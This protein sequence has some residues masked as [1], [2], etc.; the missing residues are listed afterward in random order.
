MKCNPWRWLWGLVPLLGLGGLMHMGGTFTAIEADL[1]RQAETALDAGGQGW[2]RVAFS[3]R[4][5]TMIGEAGDNSE[6]LRAVG[7]ARSVW[8]VRVVNDQSRLLEE[9]KN[10][11]WGAQLQNDG[12][13]R[14]TGFVPNAA[15]RQAIV[16][17]AKATFPSRD[18]D[19]RMKLAR[20]APAQA[21]WEG[22]ISFGLKQLAGLKSGGRV[23]LEG[24]NLMLEGEAADLGTYRGVK[25]A[26]QSSMPNGVRLR[27]DKVSPPVVKP[28]VWSAKS[29]GSQVQL[30]GYVPSER[31]RD[32]V[33]AAAKKAFPRAA[34]VDQTRV[35]AGE[36][37][38]W[39]AGVVASLGRLARLE[40]GSVD[41]RD[42]EMAIAGLATDDRIADEVRRGVKADLPRSFKSTEAIR[43]KEP[44]V[45]VVDPFTSAMTM[46]N[47]VLVLTGYVPS[48]AART[49]LV[50]TVKARLP[51][52]RIDDRL[53]IANGAPEGWLACAQ[54]GVGGLASLS[55]G[56]IELNRR[57]MT[58]TGTTDNESL[59]QSLPAAV[60]VGVG[61]ACNAQV[62]V[63][64]AGVPLAEQ[65]RRVAEEAAARKAAEE[66]AARKA[67]E[68]AAARKAAEEAAARKTAEEAAARKAAEEAASR[69]APPPPAVAPPSPAARA[70]AEADQCQVVLRQVQTEGIINFKRASADLDDRS[71]TTLDQVAKV[72]SSCSA[73]QIEIQGHT[74]AE[75]T[76]ERNANL[77][78][79]RARA[80]ADYLIRAG[81][82]PS[83]LTAVGYGADVPV[84]PNDT[85]ENR[86]KNRRIE[87][88]VKL[89]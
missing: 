33:F 11:V 14:L 36:P 77:S 54:A 48:A 47:G 61:S 8:G 30:S 37:K 34:V 43:V 7:I 6:Q 26:L 75:G 85:S 28:Y 56:R 52:L 63:A 68:E 42:A 80:V 82:E 83:R 5:A 18:I 49:A 1:K 62:R 21:V 3:G 72:M 20:G 81:V 17:A 13:L 73:A 9:E 71:H 40:N 64:F 10:Y 59:T 25:S 53:E 66:A 19:D 35:A 89:N 46:E 88:E 27:S 16:G 51:N 38:D 39:L 31:S 65:Q 45:K 22:A 78:N 55:S 87:F 24:A 74:D 50:G 84:A 86:A 67:A 2:A 41:F 4:D 12:R 44:P 29:A 60:K 15:T 58:L 23:D 69:Q 79:R 76:P 32:E 70:R 57:D